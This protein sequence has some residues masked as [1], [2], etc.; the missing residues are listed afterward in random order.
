MSRAVRILVVC[1][2][3]VPASAGTALVLRGPAT[4]RSEPRVLDEGLRDLPLS[5]IEN[6]GQ[7]DRRADYYLQGGGASVYFTPQGLAMSVAPDG[8]GLPTELAVEFPGADPVSPV[9]RDKTPA[10]VS[11]FSA[12]SGSRVSTYSEVAYRDLWPGI[13]LVYSGT[14]SRLKYRFEVDPG[15]DP[16]GIG[17]AW[18]GARRLSVND[19]GQLEVAT[20]SATLID[21]TPS[22]YQVIGGR[23]VE[24]PT[25]YSVTRRMVGFELG[26]YDS[27]RPLVIDP[28]LLLYAGYIGGAGGA[29]DGRGVAVD[30]G[31][32]AYV[33]G[34]TDS[35]QATFPD[36]DPDTNDAFPVPGAD[37][38]YNGSGDA[39]V[40]KVNASGT[41]LV[42]ATY[43][44]G[45]GGDQGRAVAVD[46]S[47]SVYVTGSTS[48]TE[49]SFPDGDG[50]GTVPG[51]DQTQNGGDD[52]FVAKLNSAGTSLVYATYLGGS[53]DDRA[54]VV[55]VD[56]SGNVFVT[57][58]TNSSEATFPDGN[59]FGTIPGPDQT[60]N[61]GTD[62]FVAKVNAAGMDLAYAGYIGGSTSDQGFGIVPEPSGAAAVVGWTDSTETTFPDGDGFGAIPGPDQSINGNT[63]AFLA[64]VNAAGTALLSA[65]YIGGTGYDWG[66]GLAVDGSGAAYVTG[67]TPS[68]ETTFPDGDG[69]G[70]LPGPDQTYNG[71]GDAFV[72]KVNP[73]GTV[74]EYAGYIGGS[75]T[76]TGFGIAAD[77]SGHAYVTGSTDS[78]E[79]TFPDGNGFGTIPGPDQTYNGM[80][81]AFVAKV[82]SG[83]TALVYAGYIGGAMFEAG[84]E[85][86]VDAQESAYVTGRTSSTETTFPDGDGFGAL[87]GPDQTQNGSYDVFVAK[88]E[89]FPPLPPPAP[90]AKCK[91]ETAT[92]V[93]TKGK[94][95]LVGTAQADVV[96]ALGGNDKVRA[97]GG[98]DLVCAGKGRDTANGGGGKDKLRGEAG[99]DRLK[100]A[101][102]NDKLNGGKG[103]DTCIG[104]SGRD[105]APGCETEKGIP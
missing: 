24:V 65:G 21:D 98:K 5:F 68:D 35:D 61:G 29:D 36:G 46:A 14:S 42:Y 94:D 45:A 97:L 49:A 51:F 105:K 95:V 10:V 1:L 20:P 58:R 2:L 7:V 22:S 16:G 37:Q 100:G 74:L 44:G 28:A 85:I 47:G 78:S 52:A 12:G 57:G 86:T 67:E 59:G 32:N 69:F 50:F 30:A 84:Y 34:R 76:E 79:T 25:D 55:R 72:A 93:G 17:M 33:T 27:G 56:G 75:S 83:G 13:N 66:F 54:Q 6:R 41:A 19:A 8:G 11:P 102:G 91:G 3:I 38:T 101:G 89:A 96:A 80:T 62:A 4:L 92:V 99:K 64:R 9:A 43:I 81:D 103:R 18:G 87:P 26:R 48:S 77:G 40:A 104:G 90:S 71:S 23:R 82:D 88:V 60:I 70:T 53:S 63:D 31:G 39:F 15:A 73:A